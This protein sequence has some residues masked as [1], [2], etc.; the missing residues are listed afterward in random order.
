MNML[1]LPCRSSV[2]GPTET[3]EEYERGTYVYFDFESGWCQGIKAEFTFEY[4]FLEDDLKNIAAAAAAPAAPNGALNVA[5]NGAPNGA[6]TAAT[7][8]ATVTPS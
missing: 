8:S 1:D 2:L 5:L 6:P 3:T 4:A 7:N